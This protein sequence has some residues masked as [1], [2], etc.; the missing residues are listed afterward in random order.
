MNRIVVRALSQTDCLAWLYVAVSGTRPSWFGPDSYKLTCFLRC[1]GRQGQR[2]VKSRSVG[3]DMISRKNDHRGS[4]IASHDPPR[5]ER[6]RGSGV[7]FGGFSDDVFFWK[8]PKQ[9]ANCA[10]L[11]GVC[12]YQNAV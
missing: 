9:F 8:S 11:F 7:A 6:D 4:M 2:F 5:A 1:F 10:F 12:Q 3:N